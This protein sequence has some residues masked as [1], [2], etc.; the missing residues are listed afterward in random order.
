MNAQSKNLIFDWNC[1]L[2]DDFHALHGC[3]NIILKKAGRGPV[4]AD[5]FRAH[6][7][8]PFENLYRNLGFG[9]EEIEHM[10]IMDRDIFHNHYEPMADRADLRAGAL[11]VLGHAKKQG[12]AA[13]I[14]SNHIVDPIKTQLKRLDITHLIAEVLAY[15]DRD[16]QF[17]HMTKGEKLHRFMK[18]RGMAPASTLIVGDS[19][20]EIEIAHEQGLVGVAITGGCVSEDRLAAAKPHHIIHSLHE[21]QDILRERRFIS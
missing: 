17:R 16:T 5:Y 14:L 1:T 20:E 13:L 15:A 21:L 19:V 6:Y 2:L 3:M 9:A 10:M 11:E 4:T 8:V 18:E 12:V 7:D